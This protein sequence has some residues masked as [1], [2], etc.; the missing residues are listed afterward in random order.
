LSP[1]PREAS[2]LRVDVCIGLIRY[3]RKPP[4]TVDASSEPA[5]SAAG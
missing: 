3:Q 4:A 2:S 5:I 1:P